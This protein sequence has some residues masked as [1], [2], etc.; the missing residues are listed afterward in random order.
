MEQTN[1][2]NTFVIVN[3][4]VMAMSS[5]II[6]DNIIQVGIRPTCAKFR[7]IVE[8]TVHSGRVA[9]DPNAWGCWRGG[10]ITGADD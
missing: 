4:V 6:Y 2:K 7:F 8:R 5:Q 10:R 1:V 3:P 9:G